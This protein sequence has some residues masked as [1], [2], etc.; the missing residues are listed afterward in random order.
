VNNNDRTSTTLAR[1]A[2]PDPHWRLRLVALVMGIVV[3]GMV[4]A[5]TRSPG[6]PGK[7][8]LAPLARAEAGA[9]ERETLAIPQRVSTTG[10]QPPS[11]GAAE[12]E[13]RWRR[14]E[15]ERGDTF[16]ALLSEMGLESRTVHALVAG[17]EHGRQLARIHPGETFRMNIDASGRLLRLVHEIA[18]QKRLVFDHEA[19]GFESSEVVDR[20]QR[21]LQYASGVIDTS[22]FAAGAEAGLTDA[23]VSE[24]VRIFGWDIDFVLDARA[25]DR[26]TVVYTAYYE[27]GEHV[28]DGAIVA[29]EFVNDGTVHQAVRYTDADGDTAYFAPNGQSMPK[30]FLRSPVEFTR[31][32]SKYGRRY[33]PVLGRMRNHTGIDYAARAGTPIR[34]TGSGVIVYRGRNGGYGN[35]VLIRHGNRYSTAY[36]HM[37]RFARGQSVGSRVEQGQVIGYVGNSGRSTGPHLHYEFRVNGVHKNPLKVVIPPSH[38]ITAEEKARFRA[39]TGPRVARLEALSRAYAYLER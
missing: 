1:N 23:M 17:T 30:A 9:I 21:R 4:M 36:G 16:G 22:L 32:S 2:R 26:F 13:E 14:V 6:N 20:L 19:S 3:L 37:S 18:P 5:N 27:G 25:G 7:D 39:H 29:A 28:R 15:V 11:P 34:A 38:T 10:P 35:F 31:I 8:R 24:L 12:A 33:H